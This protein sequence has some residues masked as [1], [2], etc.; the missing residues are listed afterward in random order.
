MDTR[1]K[2]SIIIPI[3]N[4][5][6]EISECLNSIIAQDFDRKEFEIIC[7]LDDCTDNTESVIRNFIRSYPD[8]N[9][10]LLHVCCHCPGGARNAGI[11]NAS[12][13]YLA[14][15]DGDDRLINNSALTL[16]YNAIQGHNAV[17]VTAHKVNDIRGDFSKR[18]TLWLH[19]FSRSI[20]GE[21]RFTDKILSEDYEF[22]QLVKSDPNYDEVILNIPLYYYTY[23]HERMQERINL[24]V[25]LSCEREKQGLPPAFFHEKRIYEVD[26][27]FK[28][29]IQE[30]LAKNG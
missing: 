24:A 19:F 22:V 1:M 25:K 7:I 30:R 16:L 28:K 11:D 29:R 10:K 14:F 6:N 23:N 5:Q 3:R 27:H 9:L 4:L 20:V 21:K 18:L 12:G 15:I 8:I 2:I 17:R 26:E 13:E